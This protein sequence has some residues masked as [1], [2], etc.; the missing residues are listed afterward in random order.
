MLFLDSTIWMYAP[1]NELPRRVPE[2]ARNAGARRIGVWT[3]WAPWKMWAP[4]KMWTTAWEIWFPPKYIIYFIW[5]LYT[6]KTSLAVWPSKNTKII[7]R[8]Y[9]SIKY[10]KAENTPK[11][12]WYWTDHWWNIRDFEMLEF[13]VGKETVFEMPKTRV[14]LF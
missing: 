14:S 2:R 1:E 10:I 8:I 5:W 9:I 12:Y 6:N 7:K 4:R 3:T 11:R 13:F